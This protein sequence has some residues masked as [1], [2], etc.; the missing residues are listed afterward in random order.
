MAKKKKSD[1][2]STVNISSMCPA[3]FSWDYKQ[4]WGR[5]VGGT[6]QFLAVEGA[7]LGITSGAKRPDCDSDMRFFR[8]LQ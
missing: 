7:G 6:L 8:I 5:A 1:T 3:V 2:Q 4:G